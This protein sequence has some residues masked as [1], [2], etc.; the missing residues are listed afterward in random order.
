LIGTLGFIKKSDSDPILIIFKEYGV[1]IYAV[2][3][4]GD[5]I[6]YEKNSV[7]KFKFV[8][9][10]RRG[11]CYCERYVRNKLFQKG[12]Y[13]NSLDTLKRYVSSRSNHG[14]TSPIKVQCFFEPLKDGLWI[15]YKNNKQIKEEYKLGIME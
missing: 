6:Y 4:L 14:I 3:K 13:E 8:F 10:D 1:Q 7:E 12:N 15:T 11:K 2:E 5:T 9:S